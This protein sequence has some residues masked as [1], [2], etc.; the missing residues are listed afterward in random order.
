MSLGR[1]FPLWKNVHLDRFGGLEFDDYPEAGVEALGV[2]EGGAH[3]GSCLGKGREAGKKAAGVMLGAPTQPQARRW[4]QWPERGQ[5]RSSL[6]GKWA[7]HIWG[8]EV[9]TLLGRHLCGGALQSSHP[10]TPLH[11]DLCVQWSG[12]D[13]GRTL[14]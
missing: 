12:V 11:P 9:A 5:V 14:A 3:L 10:L 7:T 6:V 2:V 8:L 4:P 1:H 13:P